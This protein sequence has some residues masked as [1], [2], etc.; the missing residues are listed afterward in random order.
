MLEKRETGEGQRAPNRPPAG[1]PGT[2]ALQSDA[3]VPQKIT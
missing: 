2:L 1:K 3:A